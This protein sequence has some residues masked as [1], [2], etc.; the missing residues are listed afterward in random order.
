MEAEAVAGHGGV[1]V[2]G[3]EGWGVV[4]GGGEGGGQAV[5][6]GVEVLCVCVRA[7]VRA[8]VWLQGVQEDIYIYIY[9]Y[10]YIIAEGERK[11][12]RRRACASLHESRHACGCSDG[13]RRFP[14]P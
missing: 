6:G 12:S 13:S 11:L 2:D 8:C 4:G 5:Q 10:I 1:A 14:P 9:I 3:V 7:C